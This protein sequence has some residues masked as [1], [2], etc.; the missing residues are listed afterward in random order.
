MNDFKLKPGESKI[1]RG[2]VAE[3]SFTRNWEEVY[4]MQTKRIAVLQRALELACID[5][6]HRA[7]LAPEN[8]ED[9]VR[10]F[11]NQAEQEANED[12]DWI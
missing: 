1:I 5:I 10:L 2:K 9:W 8:I 7:Y 6:H 11:T 4:M 12:E 3:A